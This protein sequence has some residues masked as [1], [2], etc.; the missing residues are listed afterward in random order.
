MFF[1][2]CAIEVDMN[3]QKRACE[4]WNVSSENEKQHETEM[5]TCETA[6][7]HFIK[8]ISSGWNMFHEF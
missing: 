1:Q 7:N 5:S 4:K 3:F 6:W 2:K 8:K